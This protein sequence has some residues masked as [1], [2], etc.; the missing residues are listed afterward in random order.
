MQNN[1]VEFATEC[2]YEIA[3]SVDMIGKDISGD[4][5]SNDMHSLCD[6]TEKQIKVPERKELGAN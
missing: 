3:L 4:A 6:M 2:K 5:E 1:N